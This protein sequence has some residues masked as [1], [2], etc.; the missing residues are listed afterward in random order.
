MSRLNSSNKIIAKTRA[1]KEKANIFIS[2]NI[3]QKPISILTYPIFLKH[4]RFLTIVHDDFVTT[5]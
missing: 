1:S 4:S 5:I 2:R 3:F